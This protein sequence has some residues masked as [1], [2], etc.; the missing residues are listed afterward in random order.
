MIDDIIINIIPVKYPVDFGFDN[1]VCAA[2]CA[3]IIAKGPTPPFL[4]FGSIDIYYIIYYI[5]YIF[6]CIYL[7]KSALTGN[8]IVR[9]Y[10]VFFI[11]FVLLT[12]LNSCNKSFL[13]Y[14]GIWGTI[15]LFFK[16]VFI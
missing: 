10:F 7:K 15:L 11:L 3:A 4:R 14:P 8:G 16:I 9:L 2:V 6:F 1:A 13:V 12:Y 5:I